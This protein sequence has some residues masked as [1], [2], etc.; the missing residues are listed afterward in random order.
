[1]PAPLGHEHYN[2]EGQGGRPRRYSVAEIDAFADELT[3]WMK[4]PTNVWFKDFCLDR[5]I[6]PDLMAEWSKESERFGGAYKLAKARQESRLVNGGLLETYNG[7]I[8]KF[9]LA[10]VHGWTEKSEQKVS[11]DAINPLAFLIQKAD[12]K[13]KDLVNE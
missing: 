3:A 6:D 4:I 2:T 1:M 11:G 12:G 9:V 8:V 13:S 10:N 5:D 7:S